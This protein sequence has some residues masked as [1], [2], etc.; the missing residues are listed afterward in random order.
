MCM[1]YHLHFGTFQFGTIL[2]RKEKI[3]YVFFFQ[4]TSFKECKNV[5]VEETLAYQ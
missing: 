3:K 2:F 5:A 4:I 1:I